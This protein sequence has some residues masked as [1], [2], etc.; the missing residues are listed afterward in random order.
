MNYATDLDSKRNMYMMNKK[1]SLINSETEHQ[2]LQV[3]QFEAEKKVAIAENNIN[4][5]QRSIARNL[6]MKIKIR[7]SEIEKQHRH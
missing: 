7:N 3:Q 5:Q 6:K 2:K 1:Q 4:N